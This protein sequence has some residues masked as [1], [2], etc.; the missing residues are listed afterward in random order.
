MALQNPNTPTNGRNPSAIKPSSPMSHKP[1]LRFLASV[2]L[3][4]APIILWQGI[5]LFLLPSNF[6]TFRPW[7]ALTVKNNALFHGPFYPHQQI[8]MWAA[9]DLAPRGP[10]TKFVRFQTDSH[11]FRNPDDYSADLRYDYLLAGCSNFAGANIDEPKTLRAVLTDDYAKRVY[12]YASYYPETMSFINDRRVLANWPRYVVL[13]I[14]PQ[15]VIHGRYTQWPPA[16]ANSY[17]QKALLGNK[18]SLFERL[19]FSA[20]SNDFR[21]ILDRGSAQ[22]G[23]NFLR[24]RLGLAKTRREPDLTPEQAERHF[25]Q[26]VDS[27][28]NLRSRLKDHD[29]ELIVVLMP[30]AYPPGVGDLFAQFLE[31]KV[32]LVHWQA[33]SPYRHEIADEPWCEPNDSHWSEASIRITARRIVSISKS[34]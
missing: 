29:S 20:T 9:A 25:H 10:R 8:S 27:L 33:T 28:A 4:I 7:E 1:L 30:L 2:L 5:E 16:E 14:R 3:T 13:D 19:I 23:Y 21:V 34:L 15:D 32:P 11:G 26:V 24:A 12:C 22:L 31:G 17:S 6:F 18:C